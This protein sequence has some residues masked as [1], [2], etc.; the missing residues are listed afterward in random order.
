MDTEPSFDDIDEQAA[1]WFSRLRSE[2]S[3]S[4]EQRAFERWLNERPEHRAAYDEIVELWES[5]VLTRVLADEAQRR[6]VSLRRKST[7]LRNFRLPLVMVAC[8]SALLLFRTELDAMVRADY[9]TRIGER[10]TL[11]LSDGSSVTLNTASAIAVDMNGSDRNVELL[12]GEAFFDVKP[13]PKQPFIVKADHS[14]TRVLGTRFFVHAKGGGEE[15]KVLSGTV[16]VTGNGNWREAAVLHARDAVSATADGVG[17]PARLASELTTSWLDGYLVFNEA[18]LEDVV[19]QI[20]RYRR[21][22]ILFKDENLKTMRING[23]IKLRSP[24]DTLSTLEKTLSIKTTR[25][26]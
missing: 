4:R 20:Q 26:T 6:P 3:G 9:S 2:N 23:R 11:T 5:P 16:E 1:A 12:S 18:K 17:K 24:S 10:R 25:F 15:V 19:T 22:L 14:V 8:L 13:D 21:G 7:R